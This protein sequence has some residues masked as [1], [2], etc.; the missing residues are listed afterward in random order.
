MRTLLT[1]VLALGAVAAAGAASAQD[2][3]QLYQS[4]GCAACH[5][6]TGASPTVPTYPIIAGQNPQYAIAQI[7]DI[8]QGNRTNGMAAVMRPIAANLTEDEIVAI[9]NWLATQSK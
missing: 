3:A 6:P 5:G 9:A 2:G 4:K 1:V 8:A 7:K